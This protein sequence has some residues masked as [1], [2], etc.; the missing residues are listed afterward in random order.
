MKVQ[1]VTQDAF[2]RL[3]RMQVVTQRSRARHWSEELGL[4]TLAQKLLDVELGLLDVVWRGPQT[5]ADARPGKR[6]EAATGGISTYKAEV[7][8]SLYSLRDASTASLEF[9]TRVAQQ[10]LA[11]SIPS[12]DAIM[13]QLRSSSET[14]AYLLCIGWVS[15]AWGR[16]SQT[17]RG[18]DDEFT[19]VLNSLPRSVRLLNR[20]SV[21]LDHAPQRPH[22][23]PGDDVPAAIRRLPRTWTSEFVN[24]LEHRL[25]E[26]R[27]ESLE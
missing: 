27:W 23:A 8:G 13:D 25:R 26:L 7:D 14:A 3:R 11:T 10:P 4:E 24:T 22:D 12:P 1:D 15:T 20:R 17:W 5:R 16:R 2:E 21:L 9:V 6:Q 19:S 18:Y